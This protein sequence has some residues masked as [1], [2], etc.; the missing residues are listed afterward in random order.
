MAFYTIEQLKN[1]LGSGAKTD[2][3]TIAIGTPVGAPD[4]GLSVDDPILCFSTSFPGKS[5]GNVE[6]WTQG[7]KLSLPGDTTFDEEWTV[8]FYQTPGHDLRKK[9][10]NWQTKIDNFRENN[11][12]CTP[13]DFMVDANVIQLACNAKE[14]ANYVFHN[15]YPEKISSVNVASSSINTIETFDVTFKYSDW[16]I[17]L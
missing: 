1:V 3:F 2:K 13:G 5:S 14:S 12:T 8:T 17:A 15:M 11:H 10:I 16:E 6:A 4:L 9:L 7:R